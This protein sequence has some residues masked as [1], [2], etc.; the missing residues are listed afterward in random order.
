VKRGSDNLQRGLGKSVTWSDEVESPGRTEFEQSQSESMPRIPRRRGSD[1]K[2]IEAT[3]DNA[4]NDIKL[5]QKI[6]VAVSRCERSLIGLI[7]GAQSQRQ[8]NDNLA[9]PFTTKG[10]DEIQPLAC[11]ALAA[12]CDGSSTSITTSSSSVEGDGGQDG[13]V[14]SVPPFPTNDQAPSFRSGPSPRLALKTYRDGPP[15]R[16]QRRKSLPEQI[17]TIEGTTGPGGAELG[18]TSI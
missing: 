6:E 4:R 9:S 18:R 3:S 5:N 13:Q 10:S 14:Q 12:I 11:P 7:S 1:S 2:R 15:M 16:P 8:G 17:P